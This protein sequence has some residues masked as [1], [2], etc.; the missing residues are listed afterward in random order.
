MNGKREEL[1]AEAGRRLESLMKLRRQALCNHPL[2]RA[3]S[4]PQL[5]V[6]LTLK[7][8]GPM[9]VS[10]LATMLSISPPSASALADRMEEH[11]L[12]ERER[13]A[14]DRRVAPR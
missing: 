5:S 2:P 8:R 6:L 13:D 9:T 11:G 12:I 1:T 3:I 14:A 4:L 10:D 7:E